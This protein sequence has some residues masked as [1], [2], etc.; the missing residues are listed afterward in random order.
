[1]GFSRQGYCSGLPFPSPGD[2]PDSGI[3]PGSPTLLADSLLSQPP[4]EKGGL[5]G[6]YLVSWL[7]NPS[8]LLIFDR[9][10]SGSPLIP[11]ALV[12]HTLNLSL[13]STGSYFPTKAEKTQTLWK[14][15]Q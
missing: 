4:S 12:R 8:P 10:Q 13:I 9:W 2:P 5:Q 15:Q 1:M 11:K 3:E 7:L 6:M 14:P